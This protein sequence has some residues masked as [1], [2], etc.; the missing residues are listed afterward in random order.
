MYKS[1]FGKI[2]VGIDGGDKFRGSPSTGATLT[3][4][5]VLVLVIVIQ[6]FIIQ[7]LWNNVLVKVVSVVR[8]LKSLLYTL[9]LLV[10]VVMIT[11]N[12]VGL[13]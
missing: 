4:L 1:I 6:L 9:G 3:A 7:F 8:P 10:L 11:P 5:L 13:A 12:A 2:Q